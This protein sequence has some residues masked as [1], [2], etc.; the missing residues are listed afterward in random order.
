MATVY[1]FDGYAAT[2]KQVRMTEMGEEG[3]DPRLSYSRCT[4]HVWALQAWKE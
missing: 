1:Y 3:A 2:L 4:T